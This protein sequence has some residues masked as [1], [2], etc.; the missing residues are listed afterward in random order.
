[1][2]EGALGKRVSKLE[3]ARGAKT[4]GTFVLFGATRDDFQRQQR[5][6]IESGKARESDLF[7]HIRWLYEP[8]PEGKAA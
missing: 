4:A 8:R 6:L 2:R 7:V 5:E 1:M 3:A